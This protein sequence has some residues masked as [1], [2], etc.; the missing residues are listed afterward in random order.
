MMLAVSNSRCSENSSGPNSICRSGIPTALTARRLAASGQ[1][2][3]FFPLATLLSLHLTTWTYSLFIVARLFL[4]GLLTFL[5]ARQFLMPLASLLAAIT[6]MLSG[7]F[8]IYLNMPHVSVEVLTPGIFLTF[9]ASVYEETSWS[10]AAGAAAMIWLG[11]AGGMPESFFLIGSFGGPL[12]CMPPPVRTRAPRASTVPSGQIRGC[13]GA[14][15]RALAFLFAAVV[16]FARLAFDSHQPSN[17][18]GLKAGLGH[19]GD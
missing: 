4:G 16:E 18:G 13:G 1:S 12:F 6:F 7:Y 17:V 3:P 11:N 2:Q 15:L 10:A 8:I 5:F 14:W 9:E 19:D